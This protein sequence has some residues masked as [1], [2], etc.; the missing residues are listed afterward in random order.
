M[1]TE[2][3]PIVQLSGRNGNAFS[4]IGRC[5]TALKDAGASEAH[6][7]KFKKESMSGDYDHVLQT[8]MEYCDVDGDDEDEDRGE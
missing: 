7:E 4:I 3:K 5:M 6:I 8:A 1:T 2:P